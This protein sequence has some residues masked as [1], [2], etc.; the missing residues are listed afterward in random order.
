M[1][2][3]TSADR[4]LLEE[5]RDLL[6]GDGEKKTKAVQGYTEEVVTLKRQIADLQIEKSKKQEDFDRRER[7]LTHMIG[8]EKKRQEVEVAQ[9]TTA[10]TLAVR[11]ANLD[12][13]KKRFEQTIEGNKK[14]LE[15][16]FGY[17][18]GILTEVLGRLPTVTVDATKRGK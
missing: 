5:V 6:A 18:R 11:E 2:G 13:D 17:M 8:L 10:A 4:D 12:A 15:D 14:S 3:L 1:F 9:A 16:G 7:E